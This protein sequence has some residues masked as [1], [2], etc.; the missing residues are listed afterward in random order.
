[1]DKSV[2][3]RLCGKSRTRLLPKY[4]SQW[5]HSFKKMMAQWIMERKTS[6]PSARTEVCF[7]CH[8]L[9]EK[10]KECPLLSVKSDRE[11]AKVKLLMII[12]ILSL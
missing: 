2:L 9:A 5:V 1:M 6:G 4:I 12:S 8:Y 3:I 7:Q 11:L 10:E